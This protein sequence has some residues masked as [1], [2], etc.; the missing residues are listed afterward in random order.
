MSGRSPVN[1]PPATFSCARVTSAALRADIRDARTV[2][3]ERAGMEK[4]GRRIV[5]AC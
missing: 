1:S 4:H 5:G 2:T 3:R